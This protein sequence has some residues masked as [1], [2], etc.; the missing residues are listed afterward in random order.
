MGSTA[1][2]PWMPGPEKP[3]KLLRVR[4]RSS[5][6]KSEAEREAGPRT[7]GSWTTEEQPCGHRTHGQ[8]DHVPSSLPKVLTA[9]PTEM[10]QIQMLSFEMSK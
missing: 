6:Q 2:V 1:H 10:S 5:G 9:S 3:E 4:V 8:M 7:C